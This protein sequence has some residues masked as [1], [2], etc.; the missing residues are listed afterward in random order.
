MDRSVITGSIG[1]V[2]PGDSVYQISEQHSLV[3][4]H[5]FLVAIGTGFGCA[6][7]PQTSLT[8]NYLS[9]RLYIDYSNL[10]GWCVLLEEVLKLLDATL[11]SISPRY[12]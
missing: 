5:G 8:D 6:Y 2:Q 3:L 10:W 1:D 12:Q 7:F 4:R 9:D 11:S